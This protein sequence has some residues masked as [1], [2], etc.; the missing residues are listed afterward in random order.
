MN[1]LFKTIR[2]LFKIKE[3]RKYVQI[4]DFL[5]I[6]ENFNFLFTKK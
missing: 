1:K 6:D 5:E 3:K 4:N 2:K